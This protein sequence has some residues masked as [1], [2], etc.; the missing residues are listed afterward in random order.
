L[1]NW[2]QTLDLRCV[3][4]DAIYRISSVYYFGEIFGCLIISRI[5]D[6][7]GRKWPYIVSVGLQLPCYI[8][9][10]LS[11]SLALS[12]T[13]GFFMGILHIGIANGGYIN[14]CEYVHEKWKSVVCTTM[15]VFDMLTVIFGAFYWKYISKNSN[16]LLIFGII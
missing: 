3:Q 4:E 16:G 10:W 1:D 7:V 8:I 6:V 11:R 14:V 13:V 9:I 2:S 5:P 12:T 15:L